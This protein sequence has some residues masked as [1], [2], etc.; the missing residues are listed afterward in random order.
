M[1]L[2]TFCPRCLPSARVWLLDTPDSSCRYCAGSGYVK[3]RDEE[4]RAYWKAV[5]WQEPKRA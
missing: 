1:T 3:A 2:L 5:A 4:K